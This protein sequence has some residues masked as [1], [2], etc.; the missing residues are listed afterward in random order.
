M[1]SLDPRGL[2][3]IHS[4][5]S[6]AQEARKKKPSDL[7]E[8]F[9]EDA[10]LIIT[11]NNACRNACTHCIADSSPQGI[12]MPYDHFES[13]DPSFFSIFNV[14]DF[15]RRGNP[16]IY[17]SQGK[18]LADIIVFLSEKGIAEFT[19]ALAII[20]KQDGFTEKVVGKL[21]SISDETKIETMITYHHYFSNLDKEKLAKEFNQSL[22]QYIRFSRKIL[23]SLLG[24]R[25]SLEPKADEVLET[26]DANKALVFE[27]IDIEGE[28][29]KYRLRYK[30]KEAE[31]SI[32]KVDTRL[33][34]LGRF[35]DYLKGQGILKEYEQRFEASMGEYVCPDLVRWPGIIIEPD[36]SLNLCASFEAISCNQ[37]II[38][39]IF[40]PYDEV[41]HDLLGLHKRE[42]EWFIHNLE[43]IAEGKIST[44]KMKNLCYER[45]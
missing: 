42:I 33:Y 9:A 41:K 44:C 25:F 8:I 2:R 20:K 11:P 40:K 18:D 17:S 38:S 43:G 14:A 23:V 1:N 7:N 19:L 37:A 21:E 28:D 35:R 5:I 10:R 22:K 6:R 13:I 45:F 36:G 24:D 15:G 31:L 16:L 29:G 39:N 27:G 4:T 3:T 32:P 12:Q 30:E 26:F 34:P